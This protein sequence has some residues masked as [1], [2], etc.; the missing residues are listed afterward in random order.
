[1]VVFVLAGLTIFGVLL[2]P[3]LVLKVKA[4]QRAAEERV[5][6]RIERALIRSIE[7][8]QA[9][10]AATN[11]W[12]SL[13]TYASLDEICKSDLDAI[14]IISMAQQA[15]PNVTGQIAERRAH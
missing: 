6:H 4:R 1:M 2:A 13:E 11:W 9:I 12:N 10:P 15:S 7:R 8:Q 14:A 5:L 3:N